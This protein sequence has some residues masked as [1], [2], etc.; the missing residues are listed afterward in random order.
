MRPGNFK[1]FL[2]SK[3]NLT[4]SLIFSMYRPGSTSSST[5]EEIEV[6]DSERLHGARCDV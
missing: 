1:S 6:V 5:K 2:R 3:K 4:S